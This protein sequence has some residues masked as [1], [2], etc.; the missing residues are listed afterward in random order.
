MLKKILSRDNM[1]P[2]IELYESISKKEIYNSWETYLNDGLDNRVGLYIHIPFCKTKCEFCHCNSYVSNESEIKR[3]L[4]NLKE[5][6][7]FF[8]SLFKNKTISSIYFG[9][10]TPSVLNVIQLEDI[11]KFIYDKFNFIDNV[12]FC[13]EAMPETLDFEKID[14]LSKY[15]VTRLS[16]GIQTLDEKVLKNINRIQNLENLLKN[17]NYIKKKIKYINVDLVCGLEGETLNTFIKGLE[18]VLNISPDI[19]HIYRF[20]PSE[21]TNFFK[22]GKIYT[23]ENSKISELM[24]QYAIKRIYETGRVKLK[25]DDYGYDISARNISIVDRIENAS[26]NIGFGYTARSNIFGK[27][28]YVNSGVIIGNKINLD[29]YI[30][31][32]YL[33]NDEKDRYVLQNMIEGLSFEKYKTIFKTDFLKDY[34]IKLKLLTSKYGKESILLSNSELKIN[35]DKINNFIFNSLFFGKDVINK[36]KEKYGN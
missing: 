12:P 28:A 22:I 30:G 29:S 36:L 19:I 32:N 3:Y 33:I 34:G 8:S 15:G 31:Y 10:G 9:G 21:T 20:N 24:Y 13:F 14:I 1:Y 27:L 25:N 11:L 17:V 5:E 26:S 4:D 18:I 35:F 6:I 2:P 7:L 23:D 16:L